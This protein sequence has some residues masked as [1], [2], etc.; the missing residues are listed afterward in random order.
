MS[1]IHVL[2]S[3]K[4]LKH[5]SQENNLTK[6]VNSQKFDLHFTLQA[7]QSSTSAHRVSQTTITCS[8]IIRH[9]Y[10]DVV[11]TDLEGGSIYAS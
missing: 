1:F 2:H 7:S 8:P 10:D 11:S 9:W 6:H 5:D 3:M 4:L